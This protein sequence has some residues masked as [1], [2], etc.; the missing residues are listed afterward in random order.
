MDGGLLL[1]QSSP[2]FSVDRF[3]LD[4]HGGLVTRVDRFALFGKFECEA[5]AEGMTLR[6]EWAKLD[7]VER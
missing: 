6:L 1:G 3:V 7:S 2:R 4:E 5:N